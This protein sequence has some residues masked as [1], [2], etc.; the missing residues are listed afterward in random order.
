MA[1]ELDV[2]K[3]LDDVKKYMR[4]E[5]GKDKWTN[6]SGKMDVDR[7]GMHVIQKGELQYIKAKVAEWELDV[8]PDKKHFDRRVTVTVPVKKGAPIWSSR[9]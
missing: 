5:V 1:F 7:I 6:E 3:L 2:P 9:G 4:S 8:T